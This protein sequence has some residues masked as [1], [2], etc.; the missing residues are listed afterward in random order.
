M[1]TNHVPGQL[2][3]AQSIERGILE[4]LHTIVEAGTGVGKSLAYLVPA[5]PQ[6]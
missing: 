5:D 6:R 2:Q 3:M 4:G 1:D